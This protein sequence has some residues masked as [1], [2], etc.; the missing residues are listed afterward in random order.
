MLG[1]R[2]E[3]ESTFILLCGS[4]YPEYT[5]GKVRLCGNVR[6]PGGGGGGGVG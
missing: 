5:R 3:N 4:V 6:G 2:G 1:W